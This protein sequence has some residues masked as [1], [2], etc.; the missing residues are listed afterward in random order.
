MKNWIWVVLCATG[1]IFTAMSKI[2]VDGTFAHWKAQWYSLYLILAPLIFFQVRKKTSDV[3]AILAV[4]TYISCIGVFQNPSGLFRNSS[5]TLQLVFQKDSARA[6]CALLILFTANCAIKS[7]FRKNLLSAFGWYAVADSLY[8]IFQYGL[9]I[10]NGQDPTTYTSFVGMLGYAGI[11]GCLIAICYPLHIDNLKS[12][13][14]PRKSFFLFVILAILPIVG[15]ILT[16]ASI[17]VGAL[18]ISLFVYGFIK[19][20]NLV[21]IVRASALTLLIGVCIF[22]VASLYD[23]GLFDSGQRFTA[24]PI[25]MKF[26]YHNFPL[27][28]G[29]GQGT[30]FGLGPEIQRVE[31]FQWCFL[32]NGHSCPQQ[33]SIWYWIHSDLIQLLF[34]QGLLSFLT[35]LLVC[36]ELV[37]V[38]KTRPHLLATFL[39]FLGVA[40]FNYPVH[41]ALF[42]FLISLIIFEAY[43]KMRCLSDENSQEHSVLGN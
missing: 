24:Y 3:C 41:Y 39:S 29:S 10:Y 8:I 9:R 30:F 1:I 25:F 21:G 35:A 26:W 7:Q 38:L 11:S 37:V 20:K 19:L 5:S 32:P 43:E 31:K 6:L 16:R 27:L 23:P 33:E 14:P 15:V 22:L 36:L 13:L 34:E 17:P 28:T 40:T 18:A 2:P 42:S 4:L 12:F